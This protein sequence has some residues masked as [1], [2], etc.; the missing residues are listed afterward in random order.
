MQLQS[1][2]QIERMQIGP[3]ASV[4]FGFSVAGSKPVAASGSMFSLRLMMMPRFQIPGSRSGPSKRSFGAPEG[5]AANWQ[6]LTGGDDR[7]IDFS[8]P[9]R[10]GAHLQ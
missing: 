6:R 9:W 10:H 2:L 4:G 1:E 5:S 7:Q 8:D 3:A